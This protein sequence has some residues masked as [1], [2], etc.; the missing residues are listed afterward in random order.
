MARMPA[1]AIMA[2][3]TLRIKS[4]TSAVRRPPANWAAS[5]VPL[6]KIEAER[7]CPGLALLG[8][9]IGRI[10]PMG[11]SSARLPSTF[12]TIDRPPLSQQAAIVR[13]GT[14]FGRGEP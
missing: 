13:I 12:T 2:P 9:P 10:I 7:T 4:S 11:A 1:K 5:I 3:S 6:S 14:G 8:Q